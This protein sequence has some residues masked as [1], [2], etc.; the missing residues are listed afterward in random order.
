MLIRIILIH[1][2]DIF[3]SFKAKC[4][5]PFGEKNP[6]L[7]YC[8]VIVYW[9]SILFHYHHFNVNQ[10]LGTRDVNY[11]FL[12]KSLWLFSENWKFY[13]VQ[14]SQ[15]TKKN[16]TN[17]YILGALLRP[18]HKMQLTSSTVEWMGREGKRKRERE[19][20]LT[21]RTHAPLSLSHTHTHT[22][23]TCVSVSI[24]SLLKTTK[25]MKT[26]MTLF[27]EC[28]L[29]YVSSFDFFRSYIRFDFLFFCFLFG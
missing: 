7:M 6:S 11:F 12:K 15:Y 1:I 27:K 5:S 24:I 21:E 4:F 3:S 9:P 20:H 19:R 8:I 14:I 16:F 26:K 28:L 23:T 17:F 25:K 10:I 13:R 22:H 29:F 2:W 18:R